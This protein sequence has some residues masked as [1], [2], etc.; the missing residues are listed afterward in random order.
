MALESELERLKYLND[1]TQ[2]IL[3]QTPDLGDPLAGPTSPTQQAADQRGLREMI[4]GNEAQLLASQPQPTQAPISLRQS[5]L[6]DIGEPGGPPVQPQGY[7]ERLATLNALPGY[8]QTMANKRMQLAQ[9][10]QQLE[11][12]KRA[13]RWEEVFKVYTNPNLTYTQQ[14]QM[15]KEM[16]KT[17]PEAAKAATAVNARM[18]GELASLKDYMP[19]S[20]E[21]YRDGLVSGEFGMDK[22]VADMDVAK[23]TRKLVTGAMAPTE[24]IK[25]LE[26]LATQ[27]PENP[28]YSEALKTL[29]LE[30]KEKQSKA[31]VQQATEP[32]QIAQ[33]TANLT[34]TQNENKLAGIKI[35]PNV[36]IDDKGTV[37][38]LLYNELTGEKQL[39]EHGTP[40]NKQ[41]I[42]PS[43]M[44][45]ERADITGQLAALQSVA[46]MFHPD[47]VGTFDTVKNA[48]ART[49]GINV[50]AQRI[51]KKTGLPYPVKE[52]DFRTSY[53][54]LQKVL[55]KELMGT[56]QTVTE[57]SA[58]PLAF[59]QASDRDADVTIP[60]FLRTQYRTLVQKIQ[61]QDTVMDQRRRQSPTPFAERYRQLTELSAATDAKGNNALGFKTDEER[62][63]AIAERLAEEIQRGWVIQQ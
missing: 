62:R 48:I 26:R 2:G 21:H 5:L 43:T 63:Q 17:N 42:L 14:E 6:R 55:R 13:N 57:L 58:N 39:L 16:G 15:L 7:A 30:Q 61:A 10:L 23:E 3:N 56:A 33:P 45:K 1:T 40:I 59:P 22:I 20:F 11:E 44:L 27:H 38:T 32:A 8:I 24:T 4:T 41:E 49:F 36:V 54:M 60:A 53:D 51:D 28:A 35:F 9:H 52:A 37:G 12:T 34:K 46:S 31:L 50:E 18:L 29:K 47:F 19:Q 25:N